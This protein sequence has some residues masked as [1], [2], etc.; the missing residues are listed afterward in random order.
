MDIVLYRGSLK[1]CNYRCSYC[2]FSKHGA[3][4]KELAKDREQWFSFVE[5]Y[6]GL[7]KELGMRAAMVAP[8]GEALIHPWYWEGLAR[9]SALDVTQA[10]GAQT[11]LSFSIEEALE[12]FEK[13]NGIKKKLRL[14]A[15]FH[16]EMATVSE[17]A[18]ACRQLQK[19]GVALCAGA[20]GVPEATGLLLQLRAALPKDV[21]LWVNRMDGLGR[22]YSDEEIRLF[23]QIDPYFYRELQTH[24]ADVSQC[25]N[26][27]FVEGDGR[28]RRCNLSPA[29]TD[30]SFF[31]KDLP[32]FRKQCSCYL[33]YG[34][35][36]H[37]VNQ[38][39]F[40]PFPPFRIP[41]RPKAVFLDIEGTLLRGQ[42]EGVAEEVKEA[43]EVL[44][45]R[46]GT[47]LFFA[48]T[49]P[50]EDARKR[51]RSVWHLFSGG[52][53]AAG[54][55]VLLDTPDLHT[56]FFYVLEEEVVPYLRHFLQK[57]RAR[58]KAFRNNE[59]DIYK[60]TLLC[61]RHRPWSAKEAVQAAGCLPGRLRRKVRF[62]VEGHCMQAVAAQA[63]KEAGVRMICGWLGIG[64]HEAFAAGDSGEDAGM[65]ELTE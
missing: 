43:L 34:G 18:A 25:G 58:M 21:Y 15:T 62:L 37:L 6:T 10:A 49:L 40:G 2:P 59:G 42:R 20:V 27:L 32:C 24:P 1:S 12:L 26:R 23:S 56:E 11:N 30:A 33:A 38:M 63:K 14:W 47:L 31:S 13:N 3:A 46:E 28:L 4:G 44:V 52:V 35:R 51:C 64:L 53:F 36:S 50:Y 7:A 16:P 5:K 22:A 9:I 45:E 54:A 41:R 60:I 8:Y 17:F 29:K 65:M 55:Q 57:Y 48:T 19:E 61:A 39:L